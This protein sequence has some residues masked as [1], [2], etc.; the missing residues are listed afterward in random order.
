MRK[1]VKKCLNFQEVLERLDG[2]PT[3]I[4]LSDGVKYA[5]ANNI[6]EPGKDECKY[7]NNLYVWFDTYYPSYV[8]HIGY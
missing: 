3:E 4:L 1:N 7:R 8:P 6:P 2:V 5:R